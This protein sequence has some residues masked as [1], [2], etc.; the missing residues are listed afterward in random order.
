MVSSSVRLRQPFV[1]VIYY[2]KK[3]VKT[4]V[5][6]LQKFKKKEKNLL[7]TPDV[8]IRDYRV[9]LFRLFFKLVTPIIVIVQSLLMKTLH[10][11]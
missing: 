5:S 7:K 6:T 8:Y 9:C 3:V 11:I 1:F 2:K 4:T 10:E